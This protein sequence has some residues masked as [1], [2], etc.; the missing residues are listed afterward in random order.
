MRRPVPAPKRVVPALLVAATVA[1]PAL[2]AVAAPA[3]VAAPSTPGG[4]QLQAL[5]A[6]PIVLHRGDTTP[7]PTGG[8][9]PR[10]T[11]ASGLVVVPGVAAPTRSTW[12]VT[13]TGFTPAARA[14]FQRAV[15]LWA[16]IVSSPVPIT[17]SATML[18]LHDPTLLGQTGPGRVYGGRGLGDGTSLYPS[19][20]AD[21]LV[22]GDIDPATPDIVSEFNSAAS[23]VYYGTDGRP[24]YNETDFET[25]VLHE[26]GHGLGLL[27]SMDVD[28]TTQAGSYEA[29]PY[30]YDR[31]SRGGGGAL[32]DQANGSTA[33]GAQL[34]SRAVTWGGAGA[35]R[36]NAG[37]NPVLY[38]PA[39]W[40]PG[41]SYS[42]L[43]EATYPRGSAE[44]LMT[45]LLSAQEVIRD[46]GSIVRGMLADMG[47]S[48]A[49]EDAQ[50]GVWAST[51]G[52]V[53]VAERRA[54]GSVDVRTATSAGLSEPELLGGTVKGAPAVV[55]R[56]SGSLEVYGRGGDDRLYV[57]RR[58]ASGAWTGWT[59]L[60]GVLGGP[61]A[62]AL[63]QGDEVHLFVRG[64]DGAMYHRWSPNPALYGGWENLGGL[65]APETGPAAV[66]PSPGRLE[67]V[68][69]G[70]DAQAYRISYAAGWTGFS[71]LGG[72][73]RGSPAVAAPGGSLVVLVR[74][75]D[76]KP[77]TRTATAWWSPL[78]GA[79]L[80]SPAMAS[81]PGSNR[82]DA[83]VAGTDGVLYT[84]VRTNG[85][86]SGWSAV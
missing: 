73:L 46:P 61:P 81:A 49:P 17:V 40:E 45:P 53:D 14:A 59:D 39:R 37:T 30:I 9:T 6:E 77:Y 10:V 47:W 34:Q 86:W 62:A 68:V 76:D 42:H 63:F 64:S 38:A 29:P 41:S 35:R 12:K 83:F 56:P 3:A 13:Y 32:I 31:L 48:V 20:L 51:A 52:T 60:G 50:R 65:L 8:T 36:R 18:D 75:G 23:F 4:L 15:D 70:T 74:G 82:T 21:T 67:V 28:P 85:T 19:A 55:R 79:L 5:P 2:M 72:V 43:D 69:Q 78:G 11:A 16:G 57:N 22:R 84:N 54:D 71:S 7:R 58:P 27:G 26:L 24:R 33:L 44:S 1:L 80:G 66:S 25:I